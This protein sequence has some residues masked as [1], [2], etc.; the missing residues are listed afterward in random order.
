MNDELL[1]LKTKLKTWESRFLTKYQRKP[2]KDD[3]KKYP[4]VGI[5][6]IFEC[7]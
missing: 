5:V 1:K 6:E 4:E 2:T 7:I 3:I